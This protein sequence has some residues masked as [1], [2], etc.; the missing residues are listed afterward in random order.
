MGYNTDI[1]GSLRFTR[2]LT[3]SELATV[4]QY[5]GEDLREHPE[6]GEHPAYVYFVDLGITDD[7]SG[8]EDAAEEKTNTC[9]ELI[10]W[11]VKKVRE[12]IPDFGLTGTLQCQGEDFDDRYKIVMRD[13][14]AV[15]VDEPITGQVVTCPHCEGKGFARLRSRMVERKVTSQM[16]DRYHRNDPVQS[17]KCDECLGTG[18][19]KGFGAPCT[20]RCKPLP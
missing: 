14:V 19:W 6:W 11:L 15:K 2:E 16:V 4:K 5:L 3:T 17:T 8:L 13:G 7:F 1:I 10:N 12:D 9:A 18:Y 20:K